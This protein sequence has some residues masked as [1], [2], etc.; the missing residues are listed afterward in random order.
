MADEPTNRD[1]KTEALL[2]AD[3]LLDRLKD[4]AF[5]ALKPGADQGEAI[6]EIVE[7]LETAPELDQVHKVIGKPAGQPT[8]IG[9]GVKKLLQEGDDPA[10]PTANATASESGD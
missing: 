6:G 7:E 10:E 9:P 2:A 1:E 3:E 8:E 5:G 4:D